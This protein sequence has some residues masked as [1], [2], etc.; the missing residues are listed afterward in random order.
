VAEVQAY[1]PWGA[2][3]E[4]IN[5]Q[6]SSCILTNHFP[7]HNPFGKSVLPDNAHTRLI[8]IVWTPR[9]RSL[10]VSV[11][12]NHKNGN[13]TEK[14]KEALLNLSTTPRIDHS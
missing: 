11:N 7:S 12:I 13:L 3:A 14:S 2:R 9:S 8:L 1:Q 4:F 10:E 6:F 5:L